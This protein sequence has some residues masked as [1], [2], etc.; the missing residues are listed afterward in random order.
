MRRW[1]LSVFMILGLVLMLTWLPVQGQSET[2]YDQMQIDLWPEFDQP[3]V[4]VIFHISLPE[5]TSFPAQVSVRVPS[6]ATTPVTVAYQD[7]DGL[8]YNLSAST[9]AEGEWLTLSFTTPTSILQIEYYDPTMTSSGSQ[10]SFNFTWQSNVAINNLVV[11]VQQPINATQVNITPAMGEGLV[12]SDGMTYYSKQVGA[13]KPGDPAISLSFNYER[14]SEGL[15]STP[16]PVQPRT[17]PTPVNHSMVTDIVLW[18]AVVVGVIMIA[19][20]FIWLR[21]SARR[22]DTNSR[23]HRHPVATTSDTPLVEDNSV[24]YCHQC[25]RRA[26]AGD[27]FCRTCGTRLRTS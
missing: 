19:G 1:F 6:H 3:G 16:I 20:G 24:I 4:L 18:A 10:R 26:S 15:S 2:A 22:N 25:G 12:A 11:R 23:A 13:V 7:V 17:D 9:K 8:L 5:N 21:L 27:V 14:T